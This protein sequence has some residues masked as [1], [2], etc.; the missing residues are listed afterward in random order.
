MYL[1]GVSPVEEDTS[2]NFFFLQKEK[3]DYT[4]RFT[5]VIAINSSGI[6]KGI[7]NLVR[8]SEKNAGIRCENNSYRYLYTT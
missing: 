4:R 6:A 3:K 1:N 5:V 8:M 7:Y 2:R